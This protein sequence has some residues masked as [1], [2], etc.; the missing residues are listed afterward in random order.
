MIDEVAKPIKVIKYHQVV[1][2]KKLTIKRKFL[3]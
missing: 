1:A 2:N 3:A